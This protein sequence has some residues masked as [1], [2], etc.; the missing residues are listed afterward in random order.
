MFNLLVGKSP[1]PLGDTREN[2]DAIRRSRYRYPRDKT[3]RISQEAKDLIQLILNPD[4]DSRPTIQEIL[5]HRFF[6]DPSDGVPLRVLPRSFPRTFLN[7]PL[8]EDFVRSLQ[9]RAASADP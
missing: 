8:S 3:N 7:Y 4:P 6:T 2:Y 5:D 9:L 1:F